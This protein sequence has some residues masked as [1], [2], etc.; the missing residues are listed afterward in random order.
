MEAKGNPNIKNYAVK[1]SKEYQPS[2]KAVS[3]GLK[4]WHDRKKLKDNFIK[5]FAKAVVKNDKGQDIEVNTFE[6]AI[7][8]LH[9][10][11]L[12][13]DLMLDK[14]S[15]T[16]LEICDFLGIKEQAIEHSGQVENVPA[17]DLSKLNTDEK[18]SL[19]MTLAKARKK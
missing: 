15:K 12:S 8:V 18:K 9:K 11:V 17:F 7:K 10:A 14:R 5:A 2:P 4:R 3:E 16:F 19:L 6:E 1:F 13:K